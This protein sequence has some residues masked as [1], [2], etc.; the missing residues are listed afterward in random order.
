MVESWK[1]VAPDFVLRVENGQLQ[2]LVKQQHGDAM[3]H[4]RLPRGV[5]DPVSVRQL[6]Q[7]AFLGEEV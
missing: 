6:R 3:Y 7:E 2:S 4:L 5:L 1:K